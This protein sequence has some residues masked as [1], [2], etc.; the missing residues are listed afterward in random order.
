MIVFDVPSVISV[1]LR[2]LGPGEKACG[3]TIIGRAKVIEM[4]ER[5]A[6]TYARAKTIYVVQ[7]NWSIHTHPD[8][9]T[10]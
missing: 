4:Y 5:I 2:P 8:V 3:P 9:L 6:K 1:I 7:D 10:A